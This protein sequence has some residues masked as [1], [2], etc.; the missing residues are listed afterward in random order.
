[1]AKPK[2]EYVCQ[3]CG[4]IVNKWA[5]QCGD[6][7]AWNTLV[8]QTV[9]QTATGKTNR[10]SRFSGYAGAAG[11]KVQ[12]LSDVPNDDVTRMNTGLSEFDRVLGGGVVLR[13]VTMAK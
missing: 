5:G 7:G 6:C 4:S 1:M 2:T 8:E 12:P 11:G 3:E 10:A 9:S 13:D